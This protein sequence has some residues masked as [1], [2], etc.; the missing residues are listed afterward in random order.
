MCDPPLTTVHQ[1]IRQLGER[2]CDRLI[3][4]IADPGQPRQV[5]LLPTELVL[6]S[7]CGCPPGTAERRVA[8]PRTCPARPP[9]VPAAPEP[10]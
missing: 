2:A 8:E 4:R 1:P 10:A 3:A 9:P 7:S 6:R 5:D